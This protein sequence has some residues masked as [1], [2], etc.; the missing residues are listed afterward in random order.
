MND[1]IPLGLGPVMLRAELLDAGVT[2]RE[3]SR[4]VRA[5]ELHRLRRG[6]FTTGAHWEAAE[7]A[8]RH[9]MLARAVLKQARTEVVLGHVSALPEYGAPTWGVPLDVVHL[10]R[11]DQR[12]GRKERGV[13]Q[14]QG[15]L[16]DG[17]VVTRNGVEVTSADRTPL[18]ITTLAGVEASL[19]VMNH[20]LHVGLTTPG[21][22]RERSDLMR[23]DPFTLRTDIVL[24][25]ADSRV[26][27]VGESRTVHLCWRHGVPAPVPQWVVNDERGC[28]VARLDLAWPELRA[29]LE[30][31]GREKYL[32]H[33]REGETVVDAV[34]REKERESRVAEL[35]GWRCIRITW[36]DLAHPERTAARIIAFLRHC[37]GAPSFTS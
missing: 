27:S 21:R 12:A 2:D 20:F 28:V 5:G 35:T 17:D 22:L 6:A 24:R 9:A 10:I 29:W 3:L 37:S 31:D 30:F 8:A 15:V 33:L 7:S 36:A 1:V 23:H 34:L 18:D 25:L 14:H 32:K 13:R 26:E 19:V 16:L 4:L 11:K